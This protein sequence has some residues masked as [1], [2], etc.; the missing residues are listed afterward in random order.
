MKGAGERRHWTQRTYLNEEEDAF[1]VH[2]AATR[3]MS[4]SDYIRWLVRRDMLGRGYV[5]DEE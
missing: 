5:K 2:T 1:C 3:R 4:V